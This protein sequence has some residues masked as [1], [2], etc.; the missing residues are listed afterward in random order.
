MGSKGGQARNVDMEAEALAHCPSPAITAMGV[1]SLSSSKIK[2]M[3][4]WLAAR[5]AATAQVNEPGQ[6]RRAAPV[7]LPGSHSL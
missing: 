6:V 3:P 1:T 4:P 2:E 5:G 7:G